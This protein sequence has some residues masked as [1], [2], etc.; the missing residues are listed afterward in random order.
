MAH[1]SGM[2]DC[3]LT[4]P[5]IESPVSSKMLP[6]LK[7]MRWQD[8]IDSWSKCRGRLIND[9][10]VI[11]RRTARVGQETVRLIVVFSIIRVGWDCIRGSS[12][13]HWFISSGK[14][15]ETHSG[16]TCEPFGC[17]NSC[18]WLLVTKYTRGKKTYAERW[19]ISDDVATNQLTRH[20]LEK[21]ITFKCYCR[22]IITA[23]WGVF[24]SG[25]CI[26][27]FT[28]SAEP[29]NPATFPSFRIERELSSLAMSLHFLFIFCSFWTTVH[30]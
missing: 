13:I 25:S 3:K 10:Y 4:F 8:R 28:D 29:E 26:R 21:L 7:W 15:I 2:N 30:E 1:V 24:F 18:C 14:Q 5:T 22:D 16:F 11:T 9:D 27:S 19:Y 6:L 23:S 20:S 17:L 12:S